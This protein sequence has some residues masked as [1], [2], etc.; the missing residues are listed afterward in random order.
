LL[1][2][3][4][5][6]LLRHQPRHDVDATARGDR[7][8]YPHRPVRIFRLRRKGAEQYDNKR[9]KRPKHRNPPIEISGR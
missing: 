7:H 4:F 5:S 9:S 8:N 1:A 2:P 3:A 6:E